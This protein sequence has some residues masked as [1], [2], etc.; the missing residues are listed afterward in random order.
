[1]YGEV[2]KID[3][4]GRVVIPKSIRMNNQ[5]LIGDDLEIFTDGKKLILTKSKPSNPS[6]VVCNSCEG[7]KQI[8]DSYLC[9]QCVDVIAK[10]AK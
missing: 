2:R 6:C 10:T 4:L 9:D 8:E 5:I 3:R 7:L 1:M